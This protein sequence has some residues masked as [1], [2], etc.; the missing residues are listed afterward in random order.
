MG[1]L[2]SQWTDFRKIQ[3]MN[4]FRK[5]KNPPWKLNFIKLWQEQRVLY[6]KTTKR[7]S[8]SLAHFFFL[9]WEMFHT[10]VVEKIKTFLFSMIIFF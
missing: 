9:E 7:F 8:S 1:Q 4:I 5:K 3:Y 2:D 6:T 10:E